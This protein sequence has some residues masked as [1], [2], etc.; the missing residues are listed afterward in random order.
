[1]ATY[2]FK[3][4][5]QTRQEKRTEDTSISKTVTDIGIKTPLREGK[6]TFFAMHTSL[7]DQVADNFRNMLLTNWGERMGLYKYGG[8]LK[9]ILSDYSGHENFNQELLERVR[10]ATASWMPYIEL[11]EMTVFENTEMTNKRGLPVIDLYIKYD[12]PSLDVKGNVIQLSL[13]AI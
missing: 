13:H 1:M 11:D 3:H 6:N 9:P 7:A 5:G 8:N 10:N 12:I 2:N 4:V